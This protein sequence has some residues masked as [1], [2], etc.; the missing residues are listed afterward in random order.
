MLNASFYTEFNVSCECK[1]YEI[2]FLDSNMTAEL[3]TS[4]CEVQ[5]AGDD[6]AP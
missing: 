5:K 3:T 1:E 6:I 4:I 2:T